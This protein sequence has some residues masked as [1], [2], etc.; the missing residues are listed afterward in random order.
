MFQLVVVGSSPR[1]PRFETKTVN[2]RHV[3]DKVAMGQV[4][5]E[6]IGFHL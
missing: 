1:R 6:Y 2:V 4:F 3:L 5:T